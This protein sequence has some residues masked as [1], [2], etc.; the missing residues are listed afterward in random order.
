[1]D[2]SRRRFM[3]AALATALSPLVDIAAAQKTSQPPVCM[4]LGS[5]G[6]RGLAHVLMLG[7]LDELGIRPQRIAGASIGAVIGVLVTCRY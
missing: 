5:G 4:A 2:N 1:M 3:R 7:V 6:A